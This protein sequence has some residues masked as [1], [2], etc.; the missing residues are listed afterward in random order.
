MK[1]HRYLILF[2]SF[3][4]TNIINTYPQSDNSIIEEIDAAIKSVYGTNFNLQSVETVD[5]SYKVSNWGFPLYDPLGKLID[6]YIFTA[7]KDKEESSQTDVGIVGVYQNEQIIW[8]SGPSIFV[9]D[10]SNAEIIAVLDLNRDGNIDIVTAWFKWVSSNF[11]DIWIYSWDGSNGTLITELNEDDQSSITGLDIVLLDR[12]GDGILELCGNAGCY[13]WNGG[14]YG[15]WD[16][17]PFPEIVPKDALEAEINCKVV[18]IFEAYRYEYSIINNVNSIQRIEQ[19]GIDA[20]SE[21]VSDFTRPENWDF[22]YIDEDQ[23]ISSE[24]DLPVDSHFNDL[25]KAGEQKGEYTYNSSGLPEINNIYVQG[26][27]CGRDFDVQ[28][29]KSNS[30]ITQTL[31]P[32]DPPDPFIPQDFL[33]TLLNYNQRS[34]ELDWITNQ[35][36]ADKYDSLFNTTKTLLEGNHIPW[37]DSTL[38]TVSR[39]S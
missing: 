31:S 13:S 22:F 6:S 17:L 38:Q 9:E 4:L 21:N 5:S 23:F 7:I 19:F 15:N 28:N 36:T 8:A 10:L 18:N 16:N 12:D 25:I 20:E 14:L 35:A 39:G 29:I 26:Y 30:F 37:V 32:I 33:D 24:V 11:Y 3:V 34:L 2:L 1:S 27:N